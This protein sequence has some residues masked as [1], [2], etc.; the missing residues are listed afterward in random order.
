MYSPYRNAYRI[1]ELAGTTMGSGLGRS[2]ED[3]KR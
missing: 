3:W 1:F 2:E